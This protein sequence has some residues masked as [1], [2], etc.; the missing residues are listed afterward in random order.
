MPLHLA[1]VHHPCVDRQ[2]RTYTTALTNVDLHDI[3]RSGRTYGVA[4]LWIVTPITLQQ[5]MV[6]EVVRHWTE[7]EGAVRNDRRAQ[8]MI[9]VDAADTI[10]AACQAIT[11]R[12]GQRPIVVVT[13]AQMPNADVSWE[14]MRLRLRDADRPVLVVFGTGWGLAQSVLDHADLRLPAIIADPALTEDDYNH[15]SVR[16]AAAITLDRL[17]GAR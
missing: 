2:G 11:E 6:H 13:S 1:L 12:D 10:E 7:G 3:A 16:A 14:S 15:L 9:R 17:R 4:A 8:A 5:R